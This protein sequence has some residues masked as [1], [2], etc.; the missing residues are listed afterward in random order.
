VDIR[1]ALE[2]QYLA[3]LR[4]LREAIVKCPPAAWN[5]GRD[6]DKTWFKAYHATYYA[7]KYLCA[8]TKDFVGWRGHTK[9]NRGR[10]VSKAEVLEYLGFV[11]EQ[12][13][14]LLPG[15]DLDAAAGFSGYSVNRLEMHLI[16]IRHI[17]QHAGELYERLGKRAHLKLR[18]AGQV[19]QEHN[20]TK[21][22][23]PKAYDFRA[24]EPRVYQAWEQGGYFQPSND[25]GKPGFDPNIQPFVISIPPPNVTGELHL[26]HAMFVS[27]EDLMIRYHR[28]K[29]IPTLWVPGSDH[30]GNRNTA[31]GGAESPAD[32]GGDA[33]GAWPRRVPTADLGLEAQVRQHHQQSGPAAG[34]LVRLEAA[35]AL[36]WMR[37]CRTRCARPSCV[38]TK[39]G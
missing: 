5:A 9:T 14:A 38:C 13:P 10:P 29:G 6:G 2:S 16:N 7:H 22:E 12:V 39:R 34:C 15:A 23:L 30:A 11:R 27:M 31:D 19:Q 28:M 35:S 20:M 26:G 3:A 33:R 24:T 32:G 1:R 21:R 25:P 8:T 17:Q 18:W 37:G 4:M 36:P